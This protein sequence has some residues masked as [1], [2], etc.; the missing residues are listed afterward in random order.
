MSAADYDTQRAILW[1]AWQDLQAIANKA[2]DK[3]VTHYFTCI[4]QASCDKMAIEA[5][6]LARLAQSDEKIYDHLAYLMET[7]QEV[8]ALFE[9]QFE[10]TPPDL[11]AG[12]CDVL[13]S[14]L[15]QF[16]APETKIGNP[17]AGEKRA[18][19]EK[20]L[21]H[22][23]K[24]IEAMEGEYDFTHIRE[25]LLKNSP[26]WQPLY[27]FLVEKILPPLYTKYQE[28][29]T[30][31]ISS[32]DDMY[33]RKTTSYY[34][35]LLEREWEVLGIIIQIQVQALEA[36]H[37]DT[38]SIPY[39]LS[40]LREAYQQTG[41][42]V[43]GLRKLM[44][45]SPITP[46]ENQSCDGF[47]K[48]IAAG[49]TP[50]PP[51]DIDCHTF[52]SALLPEADAI[53]EELRTHHMEGAY[54]LCHEVSTETSL[55]KAVIAIF[56]EAFSKL[57]CEPASHKCEETQSDI[58][59][60]EELAPCENEKP[61][62]TIENEIL[63][64]IAESLSIKVD[65]LKESLEA[66]AAAGEQLLSNLMSNIP[67]LTEQD[68]LAAAAQLKSFWCENPPDPEGVAEFFANSISLEAFSL[69]NNHF[70]KLIS[71][72]TAK[73]EKNATR[74][75]KETL[76]YEISTYEE[77]LYYSVSRLRESA[78]PEAIS[79]V[80]IL[81]ETYTA[82]E[83]LLTEAQI[84]IIRPAP[85]EIFNGKEHEV[86]TAEE[87]EDFKKGEIIKTMT[88]GYKMGDMVILR[89]NV[90]AAR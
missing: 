82:L 42:I 23:S 68:L 74:F 56:E 80:N 69:Y 32:I 36:S 79:A 25:E 81:D 22:L 46:W 49:M 67:T 72:T 59:T 65:I 26:T 30:R 3:A 16:E 17:I 48:W 87:H 35:D 71:D 44:Q 11:A 66:F 31:C 58:S 54:E 28:T 63:S 29:L 38:E 2:L 37:W 21:L 8:I 86:L 64:G 53:F 75:K 45:S 70:T 47:V 73:A 1:T 9:A 5:L 19:L 51:P 43:S 84:T 41:P 89:A 40:K 34:A 7:Y 12:L 13:N 90:V 77:I 10:N 78:K 61:Q 24:Q 83:A 62:P 50:C 52:I 18:I 33:T 20:A 15:S 39:I 4:R 88:S 27:D 6:T 60:I 57:T 14:R 76:L 55:A 85:H